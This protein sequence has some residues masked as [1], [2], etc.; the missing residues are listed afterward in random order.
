MGSIDES[1]IDPNYGNYGPNSGSIANY[2]TEGRLPVTKSR[3]K[4]PRTGNSQVV[5]SETKKIVKVTGSKRLSHLGQY[6]LGLSPAHMKRHA[7]SP[8]AGSS[9]N[10]AKK[11]YKHL[12]QDSDDDPW[13]DDK[14][15]LEVNIVHGIQKPGLTSVH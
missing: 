7:R 10:L 2:R 4:F 6:S 15:T 8:G 14:S 1:M 13:H 3:N 9:P 5:D 12:T 11:G